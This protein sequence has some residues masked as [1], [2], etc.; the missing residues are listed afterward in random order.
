MPWQAILDIYALKQHIY[1]IKHNPVCLA[2]FCVP[3][4]IS[5]KVNIV[6]DFLYRSII[7]QGLSVLSVYTRRLYCSHNCI[8]SYIQNN[9]L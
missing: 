6:T 9:M 3:N 8:F 2:G 5:E 4:V 7:T 1:H